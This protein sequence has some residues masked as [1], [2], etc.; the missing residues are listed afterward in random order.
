MRKYL[1]TAMA[2]ALMSGV[3]YADLQNV[4]I[5]GEVRIRGNSYFDLY[6][7]ENE[8]HSQF[9]EQRSAVSIDADF[10]DEVSANITFSNYKIWGDTWNNFDE[11][12]ELDDDNIGARGDMVSLNEAYITLGD[13]VAGFDLKIG[14]QEIQLGSEFLIGNE[15]TASGFTHRAFDGIRADYAG[16]NFNVTLL[17]LKAWEE[18]YDSSEKDEDADLQVI[19]ASYTGFENHTIDGYVINYR[20]GNSN[21]DNDELLTIGARAAGTFAGGFDY[22]LELATQSGDNGDSPEVDYEGD[23]I[24]AELGYTFDSN[25]QPRVFLGVASFSGADDTDEAGFNRLYSDWEYSEFLGDG[26]MSNVLILRA[27]VSA[28]VTEKIGLSLVVSKFELDEE[29]YGTDNDNVSVSGTDDDLGTEIGLYMTYQYSED[30]AIE[31]G[32]AQLMNGDA[33]EDANDP[34]D[35]DQTYIYAEISLSF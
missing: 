19:Y 17:N 10:S 33:I 27:G 13:A 11:G 18:D 4:E 7:N 20:E 2:I 1:T 14:R 5:G 25:M 6:S 12:N 16:E 9:T 31:V 28:N 8:G 34:D 35:E 29:S 32:A 30:V 24:N 3:S 26:D 15:D 23:A 22:E 21:S